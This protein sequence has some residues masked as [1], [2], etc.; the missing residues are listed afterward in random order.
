MKKKEIGI[1][2]FG[3]WLMIISLF[4]VLSQ[5]VDLESFFVIGFI[6]FLVIV[7]LLG[8]SYF[9]PAYQKYIWYLVAAGMVIFGLVVIQKVMEIIAK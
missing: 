3:V 6:G 4:M 7:E 1:I 5:R 8:S 2:A 9:K